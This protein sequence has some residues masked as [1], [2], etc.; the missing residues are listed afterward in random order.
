[1]VRASDNSLAYRVAKRGVNELNARLRV[2]NPFGHH[3][4]HPK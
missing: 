4:L 2:W 1:M 3:D